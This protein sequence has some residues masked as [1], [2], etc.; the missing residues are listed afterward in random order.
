MI[1]AAPQ[2]KFNDLMHTA[3]GML[4]TARVNDIELRRFA[5]EVEQLKS[6]DR[7]GAMELHGYIAAIQGDATEASSSFE[8]ALLIT[9]DYQGTAV[10]YILVM[11]RIGEVDRVREVFMKHRDVLRSDPAAMR[12]IRESLAF[13]GWIK[14]SD[15]I[16]EDLVR[17]GLRDDAEDVGQALSVDTHGF[18]E[19]DIAAPVGFTHRFLRSRGA[20]PNKVRSLGVPFEDGGSTLLFEF[21]VGG[22]P[23]Q[24]AELE[25]TMF[26]A[27]DEANFA[28]EQSRFVSIA[29][30]ADR[31]DR[32]ASRAG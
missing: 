15:E 26:A 13:C 1:Q 5:R 18:T 12:V 14:T 30:R 6:A 31:S 3:S 23:D 20:P 9:D 28:A 32:D 25:W 29:L 17:M 4:R 10:R 11:S 8:R 7:A 16:G 22:T 19:R 21:E 2:T 27:L 24:V